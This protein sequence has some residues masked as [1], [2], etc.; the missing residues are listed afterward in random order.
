[1]PNSIANESSS[2]DIT[3]GMKYCVITTIINFNPAKFGSRT[4]IVNGVVA[5]QLKG[6]VYT[7]M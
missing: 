2:K 3:K 5:V 7:K 1:M 6:R 4:I